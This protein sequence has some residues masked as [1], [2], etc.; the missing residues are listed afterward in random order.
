MDESDEL[1]NINLWSA[2]FSLINGL[3]TVL[4]V[5]ILSGIDI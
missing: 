3:K 2:I 4:K 5:S 1:G